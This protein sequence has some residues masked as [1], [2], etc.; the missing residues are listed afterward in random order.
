M[1]IKRKVIF[2]G[3]LFVIGFIML[4]FVDSSTFYQSSIIEQ[5]DDTV[6][7]STPEDVNED[8]NEDPIDE[9]NPDDA[10]YDPNNDPNLNAIH[11]A[12]LNGNII[13]DNSLNLYIISDKYDAYNTVFVNPS[14]LYMG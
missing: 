14:H 13:V 3:F 4:C 11:D 6:D 2:Y 7:D 9:S 12:P 5:L 8:A 10:Y 1:K